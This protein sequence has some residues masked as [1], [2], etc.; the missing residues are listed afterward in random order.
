MAFTED[1]TT[2]E[3][4]VAR[5]ETIFTDDRKGTGVKLSSVHKSKGL[6]SRRVFFLM[7]VGA[8]CPH[9]MAKS[10]W[11]KEQENNLWYVAVTRAIEELYFVS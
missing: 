1:Q 8:T 10:S 9:P 2:V 6:E 11:Q 7:P 4:V 3:G 5:I